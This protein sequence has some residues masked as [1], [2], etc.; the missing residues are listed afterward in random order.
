[1]MAS[2]H[3]HCPRKKI[4]L[5]LHVEGVAVGDGSLCQLDPLMDMLAESQPDNLG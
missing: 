1:M 4:H 2:T 5:H 3:P